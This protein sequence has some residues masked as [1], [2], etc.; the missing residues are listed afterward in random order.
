MPLEMQNITQPTILKNE[1]CS[2]CGVELNQYNCTKEHVIGR[3]FVPK[4]SLDG[5]WNLILNACRDCN[6]KK[7]ELEDDIS[8]IT[9]YW[10]QNSDETL[11][12]EV[13]R[14][15]GCPGRGA[16]STRTGKPVADSEESIS[17]NSKMSGVTVRVGLNTK[18]SGRIVFGPKQGNLSVG[19]N[20]ISP[21]QLSRKRVQA[22]AQY[23]IQ[24][25]VYLLQTKYGGLRLVENEGST[26][27]FM[28]VNHALLQDWGNTLQ[29]SFRDRI[30]S[31]PNTRL[32]ARVADGYFKCLIR[33]SPDEP[34]VAW[35]LEWNKSLRVIGY[36]GEGKC[37]HSEWNKLDAP[38]FRS[39]NP[40]LR[41]R[42][43]VR[44]TEEEDTLFTMDVS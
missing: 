4:G 36:V 34:C 29:I 43:E 35:A 40:T 2:Y 33:E 27:G 16:T 30:S 39:V 14:K 31:W 13:Q 42:E 18:D 28:L 25:F 32:I 20:F 37:V 22:L 24:G 8:A 10:Q 17:V 23:H 38:H 1:S 9:M 41:Y 26:P 21:P 6:D 3:N 44:I 7:G 11:K 12:K 19:F 5:S 15:T